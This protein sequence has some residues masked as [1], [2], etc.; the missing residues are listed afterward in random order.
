MFREYKLI[1][2]FLKIYSDKKLSNFV[3]FKLSLKFSLK[4]IFSEAVD[5]GI[6]RAKELSMI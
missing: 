1:G 5:A 6:K 3:F 4:E 2:R